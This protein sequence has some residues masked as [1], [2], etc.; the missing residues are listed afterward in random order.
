MNVKIGILFKYQL[1][2][3]IKMKVKMKMK[4]YKM[5][6]SCLEGS[7]MCCSY[8]RAVRTYVQQ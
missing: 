4:Q 2:Y 6:E 3:M 5:K 8:V 1:L 7:D